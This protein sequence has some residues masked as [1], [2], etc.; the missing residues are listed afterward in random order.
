VKGKSHAH[1]S[2]AGRHSDSPDHP[3]HAAALAAAVE[4]IPRRDGGG[5]TTRGD[6]FDAIHPQSVGVSGGVSK[7]KS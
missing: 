4:K 5:F 7:I 1:S 3:G 2:L 6:Y